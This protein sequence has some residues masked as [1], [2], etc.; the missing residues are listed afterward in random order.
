M[1]KILDFET[2]TV[3]KTNQ[4]YRELQE[5]LN[6]VKKQLEDLEKLKPR[7]ER[8]RLNIELRLRRIEDK[9]AK[10]LDRYGVNNGC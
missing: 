7:L 4:E 2:Q 10:T 9:I 6:K 8:A 5:D 3:Q 1:A